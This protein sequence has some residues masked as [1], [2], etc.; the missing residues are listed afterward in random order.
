MKRLSMILALAAVLCF[1][2]GASAESGLSAA[3]CTEEQF[4][5]RMPAGCTAQY[6]QGTG[7]QIFAEHPGYIPYVIVSRRP[8]EM[9]FSNPTNYLNNVYREYMENQYGDRMIGM[10]PA[11]NW[12]IGGKTL[13]GAR[14]LYKVG[15]TTVCLLQLIEVREDGDV[16]YSAKFVD[17][18]DQSAMDALDAAVRYYATTDEAA[19]AAP[20]EPVNMSGREVDTDSGIYWAAITDVDRVENG[21]FFTARL[22]LQDLY[23]AADIAGLGEGRQVRVNGQV[24]TVSSVVPHEDGAIEIV[25]REDFEG[26]IVFNPA[27]DT[28]YTALV[29]DWV[30]CTHIA[31]WKVLLPLADAFAFTWIGGDGDASIYD[32]YSF[33]NWLG[34]AELNQYNTMLQFADG[35]VISIIHTSYPFGPEA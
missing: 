25:P 33:I 4:T 27:S 35:M 6:T 11:K 18:D 32:A 15:D 16:E 28:F 3:T 13:L 34:D 21:G 22:Y 2:T 7:L 26:Y 24:Y 17:G 10:N 31:D 14:Y 23:P 8:A 9:K 20:V 19:T 30:P 29:N 12:E 5:T 1:L